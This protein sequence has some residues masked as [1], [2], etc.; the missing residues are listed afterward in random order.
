MSSV[1]YKMKGWATRRYKMKGWA[2]RPSRT[3]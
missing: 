2:T 3:F 1:R